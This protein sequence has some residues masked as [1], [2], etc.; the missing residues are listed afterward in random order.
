MSYAQKYDFNSAINS[1]TYGLSLKM[2]KCL[3]TEKTHII[4]FED[5]EPSV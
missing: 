1:K 2:D 3:P 5:L 4:G